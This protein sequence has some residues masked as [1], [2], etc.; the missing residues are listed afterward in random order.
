MDWIERLF[1]V[2]PD[3][4]NGSLEFLFF[5]FPVAAFLS[6]FLSLLWFRRRRKKERETK[7]GTEIL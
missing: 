1:H 7:K 4:G 5:L 3:G 2:S 6:G